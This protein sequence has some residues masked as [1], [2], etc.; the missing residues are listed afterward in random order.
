MTICVYV[1][2]NPPG[3]SMN[4][5]GSQ[6]CDRT[7][8]V[9]TQKVCDDMKG[10]HVLSLVPEDSP[11]LIAASRFIGIQSITLLLAGDWDDFDTWTRGAVAAFITERKLVAHSKHSFLEVSSFV[12]EYLSPAKQRSAL[13]N[14]LY[15]PYGVGDEFR[16]TAKN[17]LNW[18]VPYNRVT[19]HDKNVALHSELT[20]KFNVMMGGAVDT[21][22][23]LSPV[24]ERREVGQYRFVNQ[25]A[26]RQEYLQLIADRGA[27][28]CTSNSESFGIYYLELLCSGAVG[29]FMDKPWIKRLLP[30]Y[31][32]IA[33]SKTEALGMM[34]DV[35]T[36]HAK[37]YESLVNSTIPYIRMEYD[38]DK[39]A[40]SVADV[41][42]G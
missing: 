1:G 5:V 28:L 22:F 14:L 8:A 17:P 35:A 19:N 32:L 33:S 42:G 18:I 6:I 23:I 10:A 11:K 25:P 12:K 27:F 41:C 37:W 30:D 39:F 24:F 7:G 15:I 31:P 40:T 21:L 26:T 4:L 20:S 38:L 36:N 3:T 34:K 29:V 16:P 13:S 2:K 9:L